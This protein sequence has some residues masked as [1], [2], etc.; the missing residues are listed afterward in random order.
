MKKQT[1][2]II[3]VA[4]MA[5][6]VA[7]AAALLDFS[8]GSTVTNSFTYVFNMGA[9]PVTMTPGFAN[10]GALDG[11]RNTLTDGGAG[12]LTL[13]A[14]GYAKDQFDTAT[15]S[16]GTASDLGFWNSGLIATANNGGIRQNEAIVFTV[17]MDAALQS[18]LST[19]SLSL[20]LVEYAAST[21]DTEAAL[22]LHTQASGD[23]VLASLTA[24]GSQSVNI[25][26]TDGMEFAFVGTYGTD[27]RAD[28]NLASMAFDVIPEPATIGMIAFCGTALMFI[29][30]R[31]MS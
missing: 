3:A 30:R 11:T 5:A 24:A 27:N 18:Y 14:V 22:N 15:W 10:S 12:T 16:G 6:M 21:V 28:S 4:L 17:S 29:R 8:G 26:L 19:S 7:Q 25:A 23:T 20:R 1:I 31:L 13:T 9:N 2:E